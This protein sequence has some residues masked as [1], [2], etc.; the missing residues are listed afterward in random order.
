MCRGCQRITRA[1]FGLVSSIA[2]GRVFYIVDTFINFNIGKVYLFSPPF[3]S[4][5]DS[6]VSL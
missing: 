5:I 4:M 1:S 6:L 2:R 3:A